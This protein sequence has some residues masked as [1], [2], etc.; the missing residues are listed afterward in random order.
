MDSRTHKIFHQFISNELNLSCIRAYFIM[1]DVL[2]TG[3]WP[4]FWPFPCPPGS[5]R[6]SHGSL[7]SLLDSREYSAIT[8]SMHYPINKTLHQWIQK[9]F[10]NLNNGIFDEL[11]VTSSINQISQGMFRNKL[12]FKHTSNWVPFWP[13]PCPPGTSGGSHWPPLVALG[14]DLGLPSQCIREPKGSLAKYLSFYR[15]SD[16]Q[17]KYLLNELPNHQN[18]SQIN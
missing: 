2:S 14:L 3:N 15:P 13:V 6:G 12:C 5:S 8:R 11:V 18:S 9:L 4:P 1:H 7:P 10:H 17:P 16:G